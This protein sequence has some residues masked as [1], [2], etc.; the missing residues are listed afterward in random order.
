MKNLFSGV[1]VLMLS[2]PL[3]GCFGFFEDS[4]G[5]G[6]TKSPQSSKS[7][8]E[9]VRTQI[10]LAM[11]HL[12]EGN[13]A[14]ALPEL[15]KAQEMD[16]KNADL[17]NFLGLAYYGLKDYGQA[18]TSYQKALSLNPQRSDVHNNLGLVYLAQRDYELALAEFNTCLNDPDY[19]KKQLPLSNLGLTCLE[20]GRYN[21]ALSALNQAVQTAPDYAKA[22]QLIGR[23]YLAQG[24]NSKALEQLNH[25]AQLDPGDPETLAAIE[26]VN[27]RLRR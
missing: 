21:E 5:S 17:E 1:L 4:G 16:P 14:L 3:S 15:Q 9:N 12:M 24:N 22:Y 26:E 13:Y 27:A 25:A 7:S 11:A 6:A 2:L 23:V 20:M 18:V 8:N 19:Q 10:N